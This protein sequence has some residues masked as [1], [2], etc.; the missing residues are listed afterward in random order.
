MGGKKGKS[1]KC[2][3]QNDILASYHDGPISVLE[4]ETPMQVQLRIC[5]CDE[6]GDRFFGEGPYRL[7]K[8][9]QDKGSL[10]AAAME[11]GMAYSKA[12]GIL[13]SAEER[14]GLPLTQRKIGGTG[15]GGSVLTPGAE[16]LMTRYEAYKVACREAAESLYYRYFATFHP[17]EYAAKRDTESAFSPEHADTSPKNDSASSN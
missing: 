13:H 10:R 8:G 7:L 2:E 5:L 17:E 12:F 6:E 15:G 4:G 16:D 3:N 14:L 11:M 9:I 1:S